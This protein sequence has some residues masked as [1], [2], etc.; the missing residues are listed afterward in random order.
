MRAL[1]I[2]GGGSK[3]AFAGGVAE[4]LIKQKGNKYNIFVGSSTGSLMISHLAMGKTDE[5]KEIYSNVDQ[6][7]IF[8]NCPFKIKD[9][10]GHQEVGINH[11]AT[12]KSFMTGKKTFGESENLKN[13]I[14][15]N[16]SDDDLMKIKDQN[17]KLLVTVS[18]LTLNQVEFKDLNNQDFDDFRDYIWASCNLVPFMSL[19]YK[20]SCEYADGGFANLVPIEEAIHQGATCIDAIVLDTEITQLN[21]MPSRNP[22]SLITNLFDFMQI[23]IEKQNVAIG[24]LASAQRNI[25]LNLYYTPRVLTTNSLV[26]NKQKMRKWWKDGYRFA[27]HKE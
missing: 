9:Y 13:L 12:I 17:K 14:D 4:F 27:S 10:G 2:S 7:S 21:R 18:N 6:K 19:M 5:L 1:V 16:I 8:S 25:E 26:F 24:R 22:F 20:N 11:W 23:H 3:G 15:N